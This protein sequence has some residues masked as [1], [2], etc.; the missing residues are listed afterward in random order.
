MSMRKA[1]KK[2][3]WLYHVTMP[4]GAGEMRE[5]NVTLPAPEQVGVEM[6]WVPA[7][8]P[9][10][11]D[12]RLQSVTEG[13][14][15]SGTVTT[16]LMGQ[17][18]RCL[19]TFEDS[20]TF[21]IDELYYYPDQDAEEDSLLITDDTIDLEQPM[22]DGVVLELPFNPLCSEDCLGLCPQCGENLN[23]APD[24]AHAAPIDP[25]WEALKDLGSSA[26][27]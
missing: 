7:E 24:H 1:D 22:R 21:E 19:D 15:V 20:G 17:C 8:S 4:R 2:N 3:E 25:R 23:D 13:V 6:M 26:S 5:L 10:T 11:L 16:P 27:D 14:L 18:S 12:L 9:M